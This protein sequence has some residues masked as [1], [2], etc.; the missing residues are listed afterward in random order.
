MTARHLELTYPIKLW[1]LRPSTRFRSLRAGPSG[2]ARRGPRSGQ[3][4]NSVNAGRLLD[5]WLQIGC[6]G[7]D[8]NLAKIPEPGWQLQLQP[9]RLACLTALAR[10]R[11]P[12]CLGSAAGRAAVRDPAQPSDPWPPLPDPILYQ[13]S[14]AWD[15]RDNVEWVASSARWHIGVVG[16]CAAGLALEVAFRS[17]GRYLFSFSPRS[18]IASPTLRRP[19]P[20][21]S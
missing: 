10:D 11:P 13:I 4:L 8:Q 17:N 20:N 2:R 7:A 3:A 9:P 1:V 12:H 5:V 6:P 18:S 16:V 19:R 15:C 14:E 21:P